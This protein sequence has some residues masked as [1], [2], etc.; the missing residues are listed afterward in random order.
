MKCRV[1]GRDNPGR[2]SVSLPFLVRVL[3]TRD[4]N[5]LVLSIASAVDS[6]GLSRVDAEPHEP[7]VKRLLQRRLS[8]YI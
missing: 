1:S 8:R 4:V 3:R 2:I 7:R 5:L 6:M